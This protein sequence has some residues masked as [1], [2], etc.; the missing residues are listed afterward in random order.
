MLQSR[1]LLA[2][3]SRVHTYTLLLYCFFFI[4]YILSG[5]VSVEPP[6]VSLLLNS[7]TFVG[8]TNLLFGLWLLIFALIG[9]SG[10][11]VFPFT[12]I[13]LT[14]L[15]MAAIYA[16]GLIVTI[17]EQVITTGLTIG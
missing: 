5:Y 17:V 4:V 15:R 16:L 10:S 6:F 1:R 11:G 14:I 12:E 7:M 9:Y 3:A 13:I 8:W 2:F